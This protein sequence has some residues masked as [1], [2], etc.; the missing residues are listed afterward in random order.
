MKKPGIRN[1]LGIASLLLVILVLGGLI[2]AQERRGVRLKAALVRFQ[3]RTHEKIHN[4]L[5]YP[6]LWKGGAKTILLNWGG[7]DSLEA[8]LDQLMLA[9]ARLGGPGGFTVA[10][11]PLGLEEAGQTLQ[12]TV[13]LPPEPTG[14]VTFH[15][16]LQ[17]ILEPNDLAWKVEN[18]KLTF[19]SREALDRFNERILKRLEQ[20]IILNWSK[21]D[22]L[23]DVIE[24]LRVST[25][26]PRF[27]AGLPIFL[28]IHGWPQRADLRNLPEPAGKELAIGEQLQRLIQSLGL[29][30]EI[31]DGAVMIVAVNVRG[32]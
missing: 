16:V 10:V 19:T 5:T 18:G 6:I 22:S 30:Y 8:V 32:G 26:G 23:E 27:P 9:T 24:R 3:R 2:V 12:S 25:E 15:E 31:R 11:D 28:Q 21:G 1:A 13:T 17:H 14:E 4:H 20:P 7:S 29:R